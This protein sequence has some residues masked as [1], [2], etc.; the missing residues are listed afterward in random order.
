M[1]GSA[2]KIIEVQL[3]L[4][5]LIPLQGEDRIDS[6]GDSHELCLFC[7]CWF[8]SILVRIGGTYPHRNLPVSAYLHFIGFVFLQSTPPE[9]RQHHRDVV[10][11][12]ALI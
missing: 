2:P 4:V 11:A 6:I 12:L 1:A 10:T 5:F 7:C 3:V 8:Y 9:G